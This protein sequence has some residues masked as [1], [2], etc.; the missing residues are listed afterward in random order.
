VIAKT[1]NRAKGRNAY[2]GMTALWSSR[3]RTD[4]AV[5][6]AEP[7]AFLPDEN[8]LLQGPV[9]G[10][11]TLEDLLKS[12]LGSGR[13]KMLDELSRYIGKTAV[14]LAE[15]HTCGVGVGKVVAW[16]D[17]LAEL[18]GMITRLAELEPELA[19]ATKTVV[20]RLEELAA[21]QPADLLGPAHRSFSPDQV[22]LRDGEIGFIDF[23]G[24]C[25]AEP[26]LDLARFRVILKDFGLRALRRDDG[27]A[28]GL[29]ARREQLALME[30]LSEVFLARYEAVSPVS[31][32]R[33]A[34]WEALGLLD[35]VLDCWL[36]VKP[37][38]LEHR[39]ELLSHHLERSGLCE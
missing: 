32:T 34:L 33:V 35:L 30:S 11:L 22:L 28:L 23:D 10:R 31:R 36:K 12:S 29:K 38:R 4:S 8:V 9:P 39:L 2:E 21:E 25:Q 20:R 27:K 16:N 5:A 37:H 19:N 6:L 24:F 17:E 18:Q 7:L 1:H 13:P 15:L 14:G 3:L 26:A